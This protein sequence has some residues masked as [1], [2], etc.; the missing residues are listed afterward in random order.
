[1]G[2]EIEVF[3]ARGGARLRLRVKTNA[4]R[5]RL[6]GG[7]G[8]ALKIEVNVA[9]ERGKANEA[10]LRLLADELGMPRRALEITSGLSSQDKIVAITGVDGAEI[11]TRLERLGLPARMKSW[12]G[13]SGAP[14]GG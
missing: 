2:Q 3:Q 6:V 1:M 10:V 14:Q 13:N 12:K 9:P 11:A 4:R 5:E 8:G 7:Y